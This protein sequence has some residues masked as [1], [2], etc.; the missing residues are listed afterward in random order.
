MAAESWVVPC[1]LGS[2]RRQL[3]EFALSQERQFS[4]A[5]VSMGT[6]RAVIEGVRRARVLESLG[7]FESE[8]LDRLRR[9][10]PPA[11]DALGLKTISLGH[12]EFQIAASNDGDYF[13]SHV[14]GG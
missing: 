8:F 10:L 1:F 4:A 11:L 7:E 14:D 9:I 6:A 13:R 5:T 3:L 2:R 12:I